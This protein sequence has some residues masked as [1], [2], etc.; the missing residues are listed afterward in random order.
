[1]FSSLLTE[2][3][4]RS[5]YARGHMAKLLAAAGIDRAWTAL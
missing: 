4:A 2:I 3:K 5:H 1:L